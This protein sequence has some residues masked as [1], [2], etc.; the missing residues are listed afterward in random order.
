[1]INE[2]FLVLPP[3]RVVFGQPRVPSALQ[4]VPVIMRP[5]SA[6][7]P[8]RFSFFHRYRSHSQLHKVYFERVAFPAFFEGIFACKTGIGACYFAF[9]ERLTMKK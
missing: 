4:P 7:I 8:P 1:M 9:A 3:P 2:Q 5:P 6:M